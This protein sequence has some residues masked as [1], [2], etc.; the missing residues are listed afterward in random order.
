MTDHD[1]THFGS[2]DTVRG[3][4]TQIQ[5]LVTGS[6]YTT[7]SMTYDI[8][9]QMR[10]HTDA[11]GNSTTYSYADNFYTDAG[12]SSN[13][14]SCS[15]CTSTPTN[16]YVKTV[17]Q[18]SL[19]T[20]FGYYWGTGQKAVVSDPNSQTIYFHFYDSQNRPT[21]TELPNQYNGNCCAW[22]MTAY[23]SSETQVD[24]GTGITSLSLSAACSGSGACRHDQ[25][26]LDGLGRVT[27]KILA[28]DPDCS[29]GSR[30][31]ITYDSNGRI[32]S[33]S[34]PY[35]STSDPSYGV[36]TFSYDGLDRKTVTTQPDSTAVNTY[37]GAAVSSYGGRSGQLCSGYGTGYPIL[38]GDEAGKLRQT[39]IDG[40]DRLIE[41]DEPDPSTGSLTW[42]PIRRPATS[43]T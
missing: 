33:T 29:G 43:T 8:T 31:A 41:V 36:T 19:V 30:V 38:D 22:T 12:D 26:D 32:A 2:G 24:N 6:T 14:S 42:V 5:K 10:T 11:N 17:T 28:N 16:A 27:T 9:G 15:S 4:V 37:Y 39:W 25:Q 40:F 7:E 20:T 3:K 1:D 21:S 18:G 35:C 23:S 34:N 13:P